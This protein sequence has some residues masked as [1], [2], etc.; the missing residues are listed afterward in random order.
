MQSL[1][2]FFPALDA[3]QIMVYSASFFLVYFLF[4]TMRDIFLR[5]HSSLYQIAC[6][7]LVA[8]LPVVGFLLYFLIRPARTI[9]EREMEQML[10]NG[11]GK[12]MDSRFAL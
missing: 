6:I 2:A 5:T 11:G 9:K 3:N 12:G 10:L 4:F 7:L 8:L 1:L